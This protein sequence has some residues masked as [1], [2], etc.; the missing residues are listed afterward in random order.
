M[1]SSKLLAGVTSECDNPT[2][3]LTGMDEYEIVSHISSRFFDQYL[4]AEVSPRGPCATL[5]YTEKRFSPAVMNFGRV[6][7]QCQTLEAL[8]NV[9]VEELVFS[10]FAG[11]GR[12]REVV[13]FLIDA[14]PLPLGAAVRI[15]APLADA[16][17]RTAVVPEV[18]AGWRGRN[19]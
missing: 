5:Q 2:R 16:R 18:R 19:R 7:G 8:E 6:K 13:L 9:L 17:S 12:N 14:A 11:R 1:R 15:S 4:E 3:I 10:C